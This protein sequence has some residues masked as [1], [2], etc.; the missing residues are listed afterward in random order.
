MGN[1]VVDL[2]DP[3]N[4]GKSRDRRFCRRVFNDDELAL[5]AASLQPDTMLWAI[6]AA[7]EAAY[8]AVSR[9]DASVCSIPKKFPVVLE[10]SIPAIGN[11]SMKGIAASPLGDVFVRISAE[12][13]RLHAVAAETMETLERVIVRVE[14]VP[15]CGDDPSEF[16]RKILREEI[17]RRLAC[18]FDDLAVLKENER[19]W[20]PYIVYRNA[21]LP[22]QISLSH[23]GRFAAVAFDPLVDEGMAGT[24]KAKDRHQKKDCRHQKRGEAS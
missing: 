5:A 19:P 17:A 18:P 14:T 4:V 24:G 10:P 15:T 11:V 1:D 6:W 7:K 9:I 23:D 8:K 16:A 22:V 21:R 13:G 3:E 20:A 2:S 12:D